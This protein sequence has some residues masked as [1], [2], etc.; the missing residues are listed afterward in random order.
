MDNDEL[1]RYMMPVASGWKTPLRR[2]ST[3]SSKLLLDCEEAQELQHWAT[4]LFNWHF[5]SI[6]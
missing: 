6:S 1:V 4:T 5:K 3:R 2:I